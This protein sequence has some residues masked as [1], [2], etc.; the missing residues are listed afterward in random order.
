MLFSLHILIEYNIRISK[1]ERFSYIWWSRK[2]LGGKSSRWSEK[3]LLGTK[4]LVRDRKIFEIEVVR[5][6]E[7]KMA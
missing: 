1:S 5:D 3:T 2:A 4:I 6:K 7:R